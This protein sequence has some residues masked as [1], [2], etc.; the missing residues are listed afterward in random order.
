MQI[1]FYQVLS[2]LPFIIVLQ[3]ITKKFMMCG[4]WELLYV[5]EQVHTVE[6]VVKSEKTFV[7]EAKPTFE[8]S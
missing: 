3:P 7:T 8:A 2:P 6:Y 1:E 4:S 5:D